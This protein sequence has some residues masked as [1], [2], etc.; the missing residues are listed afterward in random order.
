MR[1]DA[2]GFETRGQALTGVIAG[3]IGGIAGVMAMTAVERLLDHASASGRHRAVR[4]L[5]QRGGRQDVVALKRASARD[6]TPRK[7][8][9][10]IAVE[11]VLDSTMRAPL[12]RRWE[13]AAGMLVHY[14]FG[15]GA[16]ALYGL[17]AARFPAITRGSGAA[18]GA[19]L[20]LLAA[21]IALPAAH[22]SG[23][24]ERYPFR[25]HVNALCAHVCFGVATEVV[26]TEIRRL[27]LRKSPSLSAG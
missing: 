13:H 9:T 6:A 4:E 1:R 23:P 3:T 22:L 17:S 26:R 19:L 11:R 15:A 5:S 12:P 27:G 24:P 8:A 10:V 20:W 14:G 18:F 7:D 2:S 25:D 21:E 16:G